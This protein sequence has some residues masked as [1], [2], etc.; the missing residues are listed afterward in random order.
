MKCDFPC[1]SAQQRRSH[2][3]VARVLRCV[4]A[5]R[6]KKMASLRFELRIRGS[7]SGV[8]TTTL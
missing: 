4:V 3:A 6:S 2:R 8:L 5:L 7:K 1:G